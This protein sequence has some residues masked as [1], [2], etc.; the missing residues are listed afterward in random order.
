MCKKLTM[1]LFAA[2]LSSGVCAQK[3]TSDNVPASVIS[4]FKTMFPKA[5]K[6]K[7]EK[8][9]K[10][11]YEA[12]FMLNKVEYSANFDKNGKWQET[13]VEVKFNQLPVEVQQAVKNQFADFKVNEASKIENLKYKLCFEVEVE[14][15][16]EKLDLL[17]SPKGELISKSKTED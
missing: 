7:W 2:I 15:A 16:K 8:E 17:F 9:G 3:L 12:E 14:K 4:S 6:V 5:L 10:D 11:A 13:E 1:L